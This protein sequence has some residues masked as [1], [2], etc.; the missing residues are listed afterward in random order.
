MED[1][2]PRGSNPQMIGKPA[3]YD[4]VIS[5]ENSSTSVPMN[6]CHGVQTGARNVVLQALACQS[7]FIWHV[8]FTY[9]YMYM[10]MYK[11]TAHIDITTGEQAFHRYPRRSTMYMIMTIVCHRLESRPVSCRSTHSALLS[12]VFV[13]TWVQHAFTTQSTSQ[14]T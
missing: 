14:H 6:F 8:S 4:A 5:A 2:E 11:C 1:E 10:Y 7:R 12:A 9:M 3:I 13:R